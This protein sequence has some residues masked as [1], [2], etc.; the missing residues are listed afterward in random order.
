MM[1]RRAFASQ[2]KFVGLIAFFA[3]DFRPRLGAF[4]RF[5]LGLVGTLAHRLRRF[6]GLHRV[7]YWSRRNLWRGVKEA[8]LEFA[9][10]VL[11]PSRRF[12]PPQEAFSVYQA[13]RT[14]YPQLQGRIVLEDQGNPVVAPDSLLAI[15]GYLQYAEQPWPIL[16]STHD[17]ATLVGESL[18]LISNKR[19]CVEAVYGHER[20]RDDPAFR[21]LRLPP[22]VRLPGNWTSI[23]SRWTPTNCRTNYTHWLLDALPRLALLSEFPPD[24]RIL[25]PKNLFPSEEESLAALGLLDRCRFTGETHLKVERYFFSGPTTMLQGYN[26]YGVQFLRRSFLPKRDPHYSG[27]RRFFIQ[28]TGDARNVEN[29]DQLQNLFSRLGWGIVHPGRLKFTEQVKLF[30]E[31]EAICGTIGSGFTNGVFC[32][33]RCKWILLAQDFMLDGWLEWISQVVGSDYRYLICPTGYER[34]IHV[35][36]AKL[37]AILRELGLAN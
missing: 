25:V 26:P 7:L 3:D 21:F 24:T 37:E 4:M 8:F 19:V 5:T 16:W 12:G 9:R 20:M 2:I 14:G 29:D 13:L 28:R 18:A 32:Q 30:S 27:P 15:G 10:W 23:V 36:I 33:P 1:V 11:A 35:D 17:R 34:I 22:P 6:Q 31:A